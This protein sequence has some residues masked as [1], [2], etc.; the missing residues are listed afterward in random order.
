MRKRDRQFA[1]PHP[2]T[3]CSNLVDVMHR[4]S[5]AAWKVVSLIARDDLVSQTKVVSPGQMLER[6]VYAGTGIDMSQPTASEMRADLALVDD[7]GHWTQL[8]LAQIAGGVRD[9]SQHKVEHRGTGLPKS[10]AVAAIKEAV[11][12]KILKR[13]RHHTRSM[14][15]FPP[16]TPSTGKK[17]PNWP[18]SQGNGPRSEPAINLATLRRRKDRQRKPHHVSERTVERAAKFTRA[19][20]AI[21]DAAGNGAR[22]AILKRDVKITRQQVQQSGRGRGGERITKVIIPSEQVIILRHGTSAIRDPKA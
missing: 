21:A 3:Q 4:L 12:L 10:T 16:A 9:R 5:P 2:I 14:A 22:K 8:S 11:A 6:D 13:R 7:Y 17:S 20:D 15:I 18:E 1:I 19:V